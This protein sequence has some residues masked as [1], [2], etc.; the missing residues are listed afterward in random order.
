[1]TSLYNSKQWC[2]CYFYK[3]LYDVSN[4]ISMGEEE[5]GGGGAVAFEF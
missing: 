2:E 3:L 4:T 1:M 5:C